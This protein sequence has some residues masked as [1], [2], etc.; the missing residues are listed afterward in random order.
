LSVG[1]SVYC[2]DITMLLTEPALKFQQ[3]RAVAQLLSRAIAQSQTDPIRL[4]GT[5]AFPHGHGM[6]FQRAKCLRP[7]LAAMDIRAVG[8]VDVVI[9]FHPRPRLNTNRQT[10]NTF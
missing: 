8:E 4:L 10:P 9:Q 6:R 5:D 1:K 7:G 2:E 3:S